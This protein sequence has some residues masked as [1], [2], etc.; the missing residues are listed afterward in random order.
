MKGKELKFRVNINKISIGERLGSGGS[1]AIVYSCIVD[2]KYFYN[3]KI[4]IYIIINFEKGWVCALKQLNSENE[5]E[6]EA[7]EREMAIL[8]SLPS[9]PNVVKCNE[10]FNYKFF[11][12]Y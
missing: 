9:H 7:F 1:G 8:Q 4:I 3:N 11:F 2:G 5:K 6:R 10:N 12:F